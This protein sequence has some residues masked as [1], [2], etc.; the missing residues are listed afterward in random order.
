M[1]TELLIPHITRLSSCFDQSIRG[2]AKD[3][4]A[5][6][7]AHEKPQLISPQ[8]YRSSPACLRTVLIQGQ[9]YI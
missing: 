1:A 3:S 8:V 4:Q 2:S 9:C 6:H 7:G 5:P